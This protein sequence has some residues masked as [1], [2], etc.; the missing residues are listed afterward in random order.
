[1]TRPLD[2]TEVSGLPDEEGAGTQQAAGG[3][4]L[5]PWRDPTCP[6]HERVADLLARMTLAE[7]I[8]QLGSVW[9]GASGDGDTVAPMQDLFSD[10]LPPLD[11]LI[12]HGLGQLT[13]VFGSRP[14]PAA[15]GM[16]ALAALQARIVAASR[17]GIPA[18]AHEEC[19][20]G[21]A[22]WKA[23]IF[24]TPLA[25][26]AS[27]DPALIR[28]MARAF[29]GNM[30][31]VGIHQGLAPVLD[32]T[33][34]PRWG[35]TEETIGED[36]Y[37]V[38]TIGIAYVQGLQSAGV[39]A[40]LK[41]FAGYSASRAGRNHAPVSMG[42]REFTDVLLPPF[43][44]A[45]RLGGARSVMPA[46]VATDGVPATADAELLGATLRDK[47]GFDGLV[48]SDYY[49]VSFLELQHAVAA[50]PEG[51]AALALTA[52]V[53]VELPSV[54]CY[55][56]PLRA[57]AAA[58]EVTTAIVD[59][60]VARV[61]RQKF[62]LGLLDPGWTAVPG[63]DPAAD[64]AAAPDLDPP[65]HRAIAR[66]LAE[67]SIVLLANPSGVLPVA[68]P[69]GPGQ[70]ASTPKVAVVGPLADDPL[71][72]FGCYTMP[73]HLA[74]HSEGPGVQVATLFGALRE[75]LP[76]VTYAPGCAVRTADRSGFAEAV[77]TARSADIVFAVVGDEAG[78]FGR[79]TS[80]E[81][82][83]VTDLRLPGVQEDLLHALA[84]TG[85][86]VVAVLVTGR[87]YAIGGV[88]DRLAA[89]VQ[90]FFPGEEGGRAIADVLTGRVVPSGKLPVE[91]PGSAG[92]QPSTYLRSRN[93]ALHP[94]SSVDPTPLF[95]FGHGL[96][97]TT[98][99][100]SDLVLSADKV[101]TDG[102]VEISCIV[103]GTGTRAGTEVVQLY[104]SDAESQ[105]VRPVRWLAGFTRVALEPGQARRVAFRVHADRTAFTGLSGERIVEPGEIGVAVGGASD[106]LPLTS[107]FVLTGPVRVV[108][109]GRVLD[110]PVSVHD[111]P[112]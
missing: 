63:W 24:P 20:T 65:A 90:A 8:A 27:F 15:A 111:L 49:A 43:E 107:S 32:V 5:E 112:G 70:Q 108:D 97:Y 104:L 6:V 80:G 47:L 45:I 78:L 35:R 106:N 94:G 59:R 85:T 73:R 29:G 39:Q 53:D 100:Y 22:A 81:G 79:G 31:A 54:R 82:C 34:D 14:V 18:V 36:P 48:V 42:P 4:G 67:E 46:Y 11:E 3:D 91:M 105:V 75:E 99:G 7:K 41:H 71:A 89:V 102:T 61:L 55:G 25:W 9:M 44:M 19:L 84:S 26:G 93:A 1:V 23:T 101:P 86:P 74:S 87:P 30:R 72:F 110:T 38:G 21:F 56:A 69:T 12:E 95:A 88:V 17:F 92:A 28:D 76:D 83:D 64:G 10:E 58:G 77:A 103:R 96:S 57:A 13:R 37:L 66:H 16:G 52:G 50:S 40:T 62:E 109:S 68:A 51:A 33:R 98:F 60:A 2:K